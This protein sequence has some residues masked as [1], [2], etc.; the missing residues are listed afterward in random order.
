MLLGWG[1]QGTGSRLW[2]SFHLALFLLNTE[3]LCELEISAC[4]WSQLRDLWEMISCGLQPLLIGQRHVSSVVSVRRSLLQ[5]PL[6][7]PLFCVSLVH[8]FSEQFFY[9]KSSNRALIIDG[10]YK[11]HS[12]FNATFE[13]FLIFRAT[14]IKSEPYPHFTGRK[15]IPKPQNVTSDRHIS[16]QDHQT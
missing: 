15:Q 9:F 5:S 8:I 12:W 3:Q 2:S 4:V 13:I 1:A 11:P 10:L 14:Q 7:F 16:D 6:V